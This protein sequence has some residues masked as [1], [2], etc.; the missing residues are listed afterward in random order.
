[1]LA[2]V[3][4]EVK[5]VYSSIENGIIRLLVNRIIR[6]LFDRYL[7]TTRKYIGIYSDNTKYQPQ[8]VASLAKIAIINM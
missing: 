7:G 2:H 1:M 8:H 5:L 6:S 3:L 4:P